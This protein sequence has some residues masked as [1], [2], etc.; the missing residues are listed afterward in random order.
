MGKTVYDTMKS[1][2]REV[3]MENS[4]EV[5]AD[6]LEANGVDSAKV[7]QVMEKIETVDCENI[8]DRMKDH[9]RT[10]GISSEQYKEWILRTRV[11]NY[12]WLQK[13]SQD[14]PS[15][16]SSKDSANRIID[17]FLAEKFYP[18][19]SYE[20]AKAGG[21]ILPFEDLVGE[22]RFQNRSQAMIDFT[23]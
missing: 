10:G 19:K 22:D 15:E 9:Y 16:I 5:L 23:N 6:V 21:D 20:I 4:R 18:S 13:V 11:R 1:H 8:Y 7:A 14:I 3:N 17:R 2:N 12:K